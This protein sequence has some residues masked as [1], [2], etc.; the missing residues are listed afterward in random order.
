MAAPT[1]IQEAE[2]SYTAVSPSNKT[3]GSFAVQTGDVL[4]AYAFASD[5][6]GGLAPFTL[7]G[8][9]QTWTSRQAFS[10]FSGTNCYVELWTAVAASTTSITV[11]FDG[12]GDNAATRFGGNVLTFRGSAGVGASN[13]ANS[14][15][16]TPSCGLT[17]TAAN[18]A[19]VVINSDWQAI[20]GTSR[21]WLTSA[22]TFNEKTYDRQTSN[23]T[24]YGGYHDDV[25]AAGAKTVGLSAP[26]G[27]KWATLAV[28]VKGSAG[29]PAPRKR[30]GSVAI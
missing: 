1:F 25:S 7:T 27:M 30:W 12:N 24:V 8:S 18:S 5:D 14:S 4:V 13:Q 21:A 2:T 28:E 22:G 23:M 15:S 3:T 29:G 10:N 6:L 11:T 20:D 17:T 19:I 16:G 26:S 9:G